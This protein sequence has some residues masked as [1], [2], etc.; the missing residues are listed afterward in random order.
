MQLGQVFYKPEH[1][2]VGDLIPYYEDGVYYAFYLHDPRKEKKI[3]AEETTWHLVTTQ[4]CF[5]FQ[6]HGPA[7]K[8]GLEADLYSNCYTGSIIKDG[9]GFYYAFFTGLNSNEN[10]DE[11]PIQNVMF[12]KG[13][14]LYNLKIEKNFQLLAD[15][16]R[17]DKHNWRDPYV[18]YNEQDSCYWML[19]C[20][21]LKNESYHRGGCIALCK[22]TDLVNWSYEEP[23]YAPNIFI[24]PEC[25]E[26]FQMNDYFY[27]VYST[28]SDRFV[29]HYLV[30]KSINGPWTMMEEDSFDSRANYAIKSASDGER[31]FAFS[32]IA[33]KYENSDYGEWEWGGAMVVNEIV[34][35][36]D[37]GK[38][39]LIP[40][41]AMLSEFSEKIN[42][43]LKQKINVQNDGTIISSNGL[44][45]FLWDVEEADYLIDCTIHENQS[46][47]FGIFLNTDAELEQG[48]QLRFQRNTMSFDLWPR[49]PEFGVY[50]WQI[51]GDIPFQIETLRILKPSSSYRIRIIREGTI[52]AVY[53]NDDNVLSHRLYNKDPG[54]IGIYVV[55][56]S[57]AI[58]LF[59]I[60]RKNKRRELL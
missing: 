43:P 38:L 52:V 30:S 60:Y 33:T 29:T 3:Y 53:V 37:T 19:I 25:P 32:W 11:L 56:G 24:A 12:A 44:G 36:P 17:Y 20:S 21:R 55:N 46:H 47:E 7:L 26:L 28:F 48:Y 27:L 2:W 39:N 9:Q 1:A 23:F 50:Q 8:I 6:E 18:F 54:K 42:L 13:K 4:D 57:I 10:D 49:V 41:T 35:E 45:A 15:D 5:H 14:S 51:A 58:D 22:S 59:D 40:T 31:R 16:I 34:Q